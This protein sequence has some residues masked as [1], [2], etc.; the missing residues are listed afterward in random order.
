MLR[1]VAMI[2]MGHLGIVEKEHRMSVS[3]RSLCQ[4]RN[5]ES[6]ARN[7]AAK[8]KKELLTRA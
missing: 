6:M 8:Y 5:N 7:E 1:L 4:L 2:L 3:K